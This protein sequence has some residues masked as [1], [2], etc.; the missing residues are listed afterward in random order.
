MQIHKTFQTISQ[1]SLHHHHHHLKSCIRRWQL[2]CRTVYPWKAT[3]MKG[4]ECEGVDCILHINNTTISSKIFICSFPGV[5]KTPSDW[6][7]TGRTT[8][9][10][11]TFTTTITVG[12]E[13][14]DKAIT[15][16]KISSISKYCFFQRLYVLAETFLTLCYLP[17][18]IT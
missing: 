17:Y 18:C 11:V 16:R 6:I 2:L 12:N 5:C 9:L 8:A 3:A 10:T 13:I 1:H 14:D 7:F 4:E 15:S